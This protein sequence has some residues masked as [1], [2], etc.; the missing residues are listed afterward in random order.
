MKFETVVHGRAATLT[1]E[2][3][4]FRYEPEGGTAIERGFSIEQTQAGAYSV[5]VPEKTGSRSFEVI[6]GASN[7]GTGN[8]ILVNGRVLSVEIFDPR[9]MRGRRAA[10]TALGRQDIAAPMPGKVVRVL[11]APGDAVEAGQGLIVVEAMK[12]QNEM[13][14]P[15]EG[16]VA[17][18]R[19]TTGATVSAGQVLVVIE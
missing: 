8:E 11:V 17:E 12:M 19:A 4:R 13:K 9:G 3:S 7:E 18:V 15:K 5:L 2:G 14:S 6:L 10:G 1:I 16:R